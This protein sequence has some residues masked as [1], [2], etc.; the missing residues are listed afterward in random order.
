MDF[1]ALYVPAIRYSTFF[2][3]TAPSSEEE[4]GILEV[5]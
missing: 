2:G 3:S 5:G 4:S 1:H